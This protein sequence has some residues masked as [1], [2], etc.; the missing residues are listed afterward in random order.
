M[1][2]RLRTKKLSTDAVF[3]KPVVIL[4][5]SVDTADSAGVV[6]RKSEFQSFD[7]ADSLSVFQSS[8]FSISNLQSV[9]A[10]DKLKL[11]Y[12]S[13]MHDMNIADK[14]EKL[15]YQENVQ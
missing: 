13:S 3:L 7:I 11:T 6:S 15:N 8:D 4:L 5:R 14:F 2:H 9:G 1:I 12:M 10:L